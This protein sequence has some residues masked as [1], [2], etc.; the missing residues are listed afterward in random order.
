MNHRDTPLFGALWLAARSCRGC[1]AT[2]R[3]QRRCPARLPTLCDHRAAAAPGALPGALFPEA[4]GADPARV[5]LSW[6]LVGFLAYAGLYGW[7]VF[8]ALR[9]APGPANGG[10]FLRGVLM[11][12][13]VIPAV[14]VVVFLMG[15]D[16]IAHYC[17]SHTYSILGACLPGL[18]G[19]LVGAH[20]LTGVGLIALWASWLGVA[21]ATYV[22][23]LS[24]S[25]ALGCA[26]RTRTS[27]G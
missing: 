8:V 22:G 9:R 15:G 13:P 24:W 17:A 4:T 14:G 27:I 6:V 19:D 23:L 1:G 12:L 2:P 16:G 18:F 21:A 5:L 26:A 11:A 3:R 20:G 25:L 10:D 7:S